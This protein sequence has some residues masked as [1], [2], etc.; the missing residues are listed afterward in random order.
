MREINW[1]EIDSD[2][3]I[4]SSQQMLDLEKGLFSIGMPQESLMEKAGILMSNWLLDR[5]DLLENGVIVVI[6]PGNNGGDGA[7]IARELFLNG[8]LVTV[9]CPL[10]IKK[11]LTNKHLNYITSLGVNQITKKPD[12]KNHDLWIDSIFGN[13]QNRATDQEIIELFNSKF[14]NNFGRIVSIDVPTGLCPNSGKTFSGISVKA[15]FTLSVGLKKIGILQDPAL[16]C[17]GEIHNID[18]GI[19]KKLFRDINKK[20]I[21]VSYQDINAINLS[22]PPKNTSKYNRGRTLLIVGSGKYPG[23]SLLAIKGAISSGVGSVKV[24]IPEE[25]KQTVVRVAPEVVIQDYS[26]QS[27]DGDS[28]IYNSIKNLDL[29]TFDSVIIGPGIGVNKDDW[30]NLTKSLIEYKGLLILDADAL[31]RISRTQTGYDFFLRRL[32]K[33]WITPHMGEF[34]RLFP[35]IKEVNNVRLAIN[36]AEKFNISILLKGANTI[37]ANSKGNAWQIYG[38]DPLTARAGLGDLLAGFVAGMSALEISSGR[39]VG[40]ESLVKYALLH[41]YA[42]FKSID[43]TNAS[44]IADELARVTRDIKRDKCHERNN[45]L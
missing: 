12:F 31:N 28:I 13:N 21:S 18:I 44:I 22:L 38:T 29:N 40:T 42:A 23:A 10:P 30:R 34:R 24:I 26:E 39:D 35:L 37:I 14:D 41:S 36:A 5:P 20:I 2:H 17:V 19:P 8:V 7:V 11:T 3:L 4:V 9:W 33:T 45:L 43:G 1:P 15:N 6:G 27:I 16:D 32:F 25:L